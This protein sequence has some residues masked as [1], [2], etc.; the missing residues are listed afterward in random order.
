MYVL[1][2]GAWKYH[3]GCGFDAR[4]GLRNRFPEGRA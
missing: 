1:N 4:P 3:G 2:V